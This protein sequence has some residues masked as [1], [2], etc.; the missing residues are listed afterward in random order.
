MRDETL[1]LLKVIT[2]DQL[3]LSGRIDRMSKRLDA[4]E[5]RLNPPKVPVTPSAPT[6]MGW[7]SD[8]PVGERLFRAYAKHGKIGD[9]LDELGALYAEA[10]QL[11][12]GKVKK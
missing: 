5:K 3:A 2:D 4:I 12:Y 9:A 6:I 7:P 8:T 11:F 1:Q 10:E